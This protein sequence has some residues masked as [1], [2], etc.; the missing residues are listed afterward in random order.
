MKPTLPS[1][2]FNLILLL[3]LCIDIANAQTYKIV[4]TDQTTF[5]DTITIISAPLVGEC[6]LWSGCTVFR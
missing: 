2:F 4:D 1:K 6:F 3:L 5:Y